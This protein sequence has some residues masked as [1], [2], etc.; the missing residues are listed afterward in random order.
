MSLVAFLDSLPGLVSSETALSLSFCHLL[1]NHIIKDC[2][3]W[4]AVQSL[5]ACHNEFS[6]KQGR[7]LIFPVTCGRH[8]CLA[9][10]LCSTCHQTI[11]HA[12]HSTCPVC[13][14][15]LRSPALTTA[16]STLRSWHK[17]HLLKW[18]LCIPA[19]RRHPASSPAR[20]GPDGATARAH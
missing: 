18:A 12:T 14:P 11:N 2:S 5:T 9:W 4:A 8:P 6:E 19:I 1:P 16:A 3:L 7:K 15:Q 13:N 10:M 17:H 20:P